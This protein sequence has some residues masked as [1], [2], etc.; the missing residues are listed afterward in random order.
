MK[1][2]ISVVLAAVMMLSVSGCSA[3]P[4]TALTVEGTALN[5]EIFA[6]YLD[7]VAASPES[8][9]LGK[10]A[11]EK[12]LKDA[13]VRECK[14]YIAVNTDF[15]NSGKQLTSAQKV[16]IS[17]RVNNIWM[18]SENHYNSIGVTKQTLNKIVT[19]GKY[20]EA[21]FTALYD[22]GVGDVAAEKAIQSYFYDNYVSFLTVCAYFSSANGTPMTQLEKTEMLNFFSSLSDGKTITAEEFE[23]SFA[24]TGY[25]VSDTVILKRNSDGY[26]EGFF[27]SVRAQTD[28][29]VQIIIY[30]DCVFAIYKEN[31]ADK[32][33]GVYAAYRTACINDLYAERNEE[34]IE[35][36]TEGLS[37]DENSK[38]I[39]SVYKAIVK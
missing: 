33:E 7:R 15:V 23:K 13:A 38:V 32:G 10:D 18:R 9:A 25:A 39:D 11:S 34:R 29:T 20:E 30:D 16:E 12:E 6:Y 5:S 28:S 4:K 31:L 8:Y 37:V 2:F 27:D 14:R 3:K 24:D 22:K 26:P 1:K 17:E 19:A 36:L 21:V 35:K